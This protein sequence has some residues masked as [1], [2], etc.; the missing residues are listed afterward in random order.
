MAD[1]FN[2]NVTIGNQTIQIEGICQW[3]ILDFHNWIQKRPFG[4]SFPSPVFQI[5]SV[6]PVPVI[7][8]QIK[9]T[10]VQDKKKI[11]FHMKNVGSHPIKVVRICPETNFLFNIENTTI[12]PNEISDEN[13]ASIYACPEEK[14]L[15]MEITLKF[16]H[17][18]KRNKPV[19]PV[20]GSLI[21][22]LNHELENSELSDVILV[23]HGKEFKCLRNMLALR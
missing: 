22:D 15:K 2:S 3:T 19:E 16:E 8:F 6:L 7:K 5:Q 13:F 4:E 12:F 17:I 11:S 14:D 20:I 1:F 23:C 18:I 10:R 21:H 9:L